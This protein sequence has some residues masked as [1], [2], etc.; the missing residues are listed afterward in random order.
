MDISI[1]VTCYNEEKNIKECLES[2]AAQD[3]NRGTYEVIVSDG[4][5]TDKTRGIVQEYAESFSNMRLVVETKRGTAAGRNRGVKLARYDYV[6]FIDADCLA[7]HNW[8]TVLAENYMRSKNQYPRLVAVGGRNITPEGADSFN[9][10]VEIALDSYLGSFNSVQ[11]RQFKTPALVASVS[12]VNALY[13]KDKI[14]GIGCFDE[15]LKSEAE[16]AEMNYR[17]SAAGNQF[18]F[19]PDSFVWHKMRSSPLAWIKNMFRY[20]K[21]RARLLKRYPAMRRFFFWL[22]AIFLVSMI[23]IPFA[24]CAKIF[25]LPLLYFPFIFLFSLYRCLTKRRLA[26]LVPV[27]AVYIIQHFAYACG[28]MYG[29]INPEVQ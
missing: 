1:V 25:Y 9:R 4:D 28:Q 8:L 10:A 21:G 14:I 13:A 17:L 26:L 16:D 6:A 19:V 23:S 11:G 24:A 18:L 3:Y 27:T 20:G 29:L 2:L 12:T 15:S 5:S 22:P 7:P